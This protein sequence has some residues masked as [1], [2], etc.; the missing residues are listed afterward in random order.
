MAIIN[1]YQGILVGGKSSYDAS[2]TSVSKVGDFNGDGYGDIAIGSP[3]ASPRDRTNAGVVTI[4][5]GNYG[6]TI[7][8]VINLAN[9]KY[10]YSQIFG[11]NSGDKCGILV[12]DAGD[13]N[14]DMYNDMIISCY[15]SSPN[16]L[17]D[18]GA[19]Y[20]IY[21]R[22]NIFNIDLAN[23]ANHDGFAIYGAN[24]QDNFGFSISKAGD[25]NSDGFDD[26]VVGSPIASPNAKT[27]SGIAYVIF[28]KNN[29]QTIDLSL[30][31]DQ[32]KVLQ[33]FGAS[34]GDYLGY[35]VSGR[36]L[37]LGHGSDLIISANSAS[38]NSRIN[39]GTTYI[40]FGDVKEGVM[41]LNKF[42]LSMGIKIY[43]A[44]TGDF[45]GSSAFSDE[46][47]NIDG[48]LSLAIAAPFASPYSR[49]QAGEI[50][51][52]NSLNFT[53]N[54]DLANFNTKLGSKIIGASSN[55][56]TGS[57]IK[58]AGDTNNDGYS[59]VIIGLPQAPYLSRKQGG[60]SFV[61]YGSSKNKIVDL[62]TLD[63]AQGLI[64]VGAN[65]LDYSGTSVN[66]A[67]DFNG[68]GYA[69]IAI[70]S[71]GASPNSKTRSGSVSILYGGYN[72]PSSQ[73]S[74]RPT[75]QPILNP[76][77]VPTSQPNSDPTSMPT[78]SPTTM[79]TEAEIE[80]S[81]PSSQSTAIALISAGGVFF[82]SWLF[83]GV[84]YDAFKKYIL[85]PYS[86][87]FW[88]HG[89]KYVWEHGVEVF[90]WL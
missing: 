40:I 20:V 25:V 26:I 52:L 67:G 85:D 3:D 53:S 60:K 70:G 69:D 63:S 1:S 34:A 16:Q 24:S 36:N 44:N 28:G 35:S 7:P 17:T 88:N 29:S 57:I 86:E 80:K 50:Y 78:S 79:P 30:A 56:K 32:K 61:V 54:I 22:K 77:S 43:G 75:S 9:N 64:I 27:N 21:G 18:S 71:P 8:S 74:S 38:D 76:T 66:S 5:Y 15:Y 39:S 90:I 31:L 47:I 41:D 87:Y 51:I 65:S 82:A 89:G 23:L 62:K 73:P 13:V 4:I 2:G 11:A 37:K 84:L 81:K 6:N 55:D 12:S 83:Q 45:S 49:F 58:D 46:S 42:N 59:D 48:K 68:D 19:V 14:N 72:V 33:I 10:P